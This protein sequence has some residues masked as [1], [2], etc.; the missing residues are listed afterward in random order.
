MQFECNDATLENTRLSHKKLEEIIQAQTSIARLGIN[1]EAIL[2]QVAQESQDLTNAHGAVIELIENDE[3]VIRAAS[4]IASHYYGV[5]RSSA[6]NMSSIAI[7]TKHALIANDTENDSRVDQVSRVGIGHRSMIVFPL[8]H[9]KKVVGV[10]KV[11]SKKPNFYS[12]AELKIIAYMSD[13]VASTMYHAQYYAQDELFRRATQDELTGIANRALFMDHLYTN[14]AHAKRNES[15]LAVIAIDMDDLKILND[16]YGHHI[17][18]KALQT[19]AAKFSEQIRSSDTVARFGGDEF[20]IILSPVSGKDSAE[21]VV[22]SIVQSLDEPMTEEDLDFKLGASFGIAIYPDDNENADSL[23]EMAD[24]N[25]FKNKRERKKQR[26]YII[27]I[28]NLE[29]PL[30]AY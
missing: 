26:T 28:L 6:N 3:I 10:L 21:A 24:K 20:A 16:S 4:G 22:N 19:L 5:R 11:L 13:L 15:K 27:V 29:P 17:G 18:D 7:K 9:E 1:F 12:M 30:K 14:I 25:M 8:F 23:L 2:N